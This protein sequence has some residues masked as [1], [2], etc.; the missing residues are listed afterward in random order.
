ML[1][2]SVNEVNNHTTK[3]CEKTRAVFHEGINTLQDQVKSEGEGLKEAIQQEGSKTETQ[4]TSLQDQ[5]TS[6]GLQTATK[7]KEIQRQGDSNANELKDVSKQLLYLTDLVE[8]SAKK[9]YRPFDQSDID[10]LDDESTVANM[11]SLKSVLASESVHSPLSACTNDDELCNQKKRSSSPLKEEETGP[12]KKRLKSLIGGW[13]NTIS[14]KK[15]SG[16]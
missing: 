8:K 9:K 5:V 1:D 14:G 10:E 3:E 16:S 2:A 11:I 6:E 13:K 15:D 7:L 12:M 4:L